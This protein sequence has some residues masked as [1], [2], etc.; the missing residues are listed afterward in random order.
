MHTVIRAHVYTIRITYTV[1]DAAADDESSV[2]DAL[3][4]QL[5]PAL[6]DIL[7][8]AHASQVSKVCTHIY[9]PHTNKHFC[10]HCEVSPYML[11]S[12][13]GRCFLRASL[14]ELSV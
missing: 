11:I 12:T 3:A 9:T 6:K 14:F 8:R 10:Q 4:S 1:E 2:R 5:A 13:Q 7:P